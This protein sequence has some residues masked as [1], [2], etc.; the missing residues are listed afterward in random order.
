M[1]PSSTEQLSL[2]HSLASGERKWVAAGRPWQDG[3][4]NYCFADDTSPRTK[5]VFEVAAQQYTNSV[6]CLKFQNVGWESGRSDDS[7]AA[8]RCKISPA[9]FVISRKSAGC[10]SY[11]GM[12][13]SMRSQQLQLNDPACISIGTAIHELGHALGMAH[14]QSRPDRDDY[15]TVDYSNIDAQH[16][17]DFQVMQ[18]AYTGLPYDFLSIMHYDAFA[19]AVDKTKPSLTA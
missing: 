5:H 9:I 14:E 12:V 19:F 6:P 18:G 4:V 16:A 3:V 17:H 7:L 10:Y 13:T 11:V 8:Q 1:V 2:L 15:V